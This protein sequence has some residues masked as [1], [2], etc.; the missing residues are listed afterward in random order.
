[1]STATER[2]TVHVKSGGACADEYAYEPPPTRDR[3]PT[4]PEDLTEY[5]WLHTGPPARL[6]E[7]MMMAEDGSDCRDRFTEIA[8]LDP[9]D[10]ED[11]EDDDDDDDDELYFEPASIDDMTT[12]LLVD[13]WHSDVPNIISYVSPGPTATQKM[14]VDEREA[15]VLSMMDGTAT[16]GTLLESSGLPVADVLDTLCDLCARG[17]VILDRSRRIALQTEASSEVEGPQLA[18]P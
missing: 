5:A 3:L 6:L 18:A 15:R 1:M 8:E 9:N 10:V 14:L 12:G 2:E 7:E 11:V 17:V 16:V 13:L 4:L